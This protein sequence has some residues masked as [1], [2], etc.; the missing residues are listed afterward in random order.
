MS[1]QRVSPYRY[2][3]NERRALAG[4]GVTSVISAQVETLALILVVP[5]ANSVASNE[6]SFSG[7]I[8]PITITS[9][10]GRLAAI[11]AVAII[12][13]AAFN[14]FIAWQLARLTT[15]WE[16]ERRQQVVGHYLRAD[17]PM[18]T[19]ERQGKLSTI[20]D[21]AAFGAGAL[22]SLASEI[23]AGLTIVVFVG[24]A[25]FIDPIGAVCMLAAVVVLSM[26][27][28]PALTK[29]KKYGHALSSMS[30]AYN[31]ELIEATR[32]V[33]D[34][35]VFGVLGPLG[36]RLDDQFRRISRVKL[37][38]N[39]VGATTSP[40]YQYLGMLFIV[41]ILAA[42]NS[43]SSLDP[44]EFGAIALL[45]LRGLSFG[46]Q[47]QSNRQALASQAPFL[48][49]LE[50]LDQSYIERATHDGHV[51]L[52]AVHRIDLENVHYSYDGQTD[53]LSDI[54]LSLRVGE[55]VGIVGASGSGKSTLSQLLLRLREPTGGSVRVNGVP[56]NDYTLASWA[57]RITLVPQDPQLLHATV[58]EN[59]A[60]LDTSIDSETVV[61]AAKAV[62]LHDMILELEQGYETLIGPAFRDLSGGQIQRIGIAR[63]LARKAHV[64]VLDE[65][66]S[67]L[68]VH[69]EAVIQGTIESLHDHALVVIIAHR[70]S[71][72]SI[73]DRVVVLQRGRLESVGT[74]ADVAERSDYFRHALEV[75][76]LDVRDPSPRRNLPAQDA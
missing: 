21:Y 38:A 70:L 52:E 17:Y 28:R 9:S 22:G 24:A 3:R 44:A 64:I 49:K 1:E 16:L 41:G 71:T 43:L 56:A 2:F 63:A 33:R 65:P 40:L 75:G 39:F 11:A 45:L 53:V 15:R 6:G 18:Q 7:K 54:D 55:I 59:I 25:I 13:A 26:V 5:L 12:L 20:S 34:V 19:G 47:L 76:S 72:L 30:V 51:A 74:L 36:Q 29:G 10:A 60:F 4:I 61:E 31:Q 73:C 46:Q 32:M 23:K 37:R 14:V 67:A 35:R 57:H 62:G 68:D 8:G 50:E 69:S 27:L 58:A 42:A 66:T 48:Q